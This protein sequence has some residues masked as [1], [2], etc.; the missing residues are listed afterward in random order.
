[1]PG[2]LNLSE[3]KR[4]ALRW[5]LDEME[6]RSTPPDLRERMAEYRRRQEEVEAEVRRRMFGDAHA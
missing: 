3:E 4:D 6:R 2:P 1:M 5:L